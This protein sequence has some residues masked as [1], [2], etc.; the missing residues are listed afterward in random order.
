MLSYLFHQA[1]SR[2]Y[3]LFL[4]HRF[5][6]VT[7]FQ[8]IERTDTCRIAKDKIFRNSWSKRTRGNQ[9]KAPKIYLLMF[10][11]RPIFHLNF[12]II[13]QENTLNNNYF[14]FLFP[15]NNKNYIYIQFYLMIQGNDR[16]FNSR[17]F[18]YLYIQY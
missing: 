17:K 5:T 14:S 18:S 1:Y 8:A 3:S 13:V 10:S 6:K 7:D 4:M 2:H 16:G 9:R 11:I 15:K 12:I